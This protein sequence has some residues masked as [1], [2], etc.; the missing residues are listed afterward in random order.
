[1]P[2]ETWQPIVSGSQRQ[3]DFMAKHNMKGI[4]GGGAAAGGATDRVMEAWRDANAKVGRDLELGENLAVGYSVYI[5][6]SEEKAIEEARP[7]FEENIKMFAPLGFVPGL[8]EDQI[9][10]IGDP[11][12]VRSAN[13]PTLEKAVEDGSWLVGPAER[14]TEKLMAIQERYP[15]LDSINVGYPIGT[16]SSVILEQLEAFAEGVMPAFKSQVKAPASA[17]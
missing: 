1:M 3:L 15:G 13:P 16:P 9:S 17:D 4:I 8:T 14:I 10:A 12:R 5:A 6:E 7:F 2:V 11:R